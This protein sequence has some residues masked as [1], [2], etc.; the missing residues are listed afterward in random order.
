MSI[1]NKTIYYLLDNFYFKYLSSTLFFKEYK[2]IRYYKVLLKL[3]KAK[4]EDFFISRL[5]PLA[6]N[7]YKKEV[8]FNIVNLKTLYH[9]SDILTKII[10]LKLKNRKN[11]LLKVLRSALSLVRLPK[12]NVIRER[13]HKTLRN[14]L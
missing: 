9:N 10:A 8:E 12:V 5:K 13:Y 11:K 14:E 3:N 2:A 6:K 4:F 1:K 7:I